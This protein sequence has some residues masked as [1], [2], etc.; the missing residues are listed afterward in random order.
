[1]LYLVRKT[2]N[3]VHHKFKKTH[4]R[5][6]IQ[7]AECLTG[8]GPA[9]AHLCH[10]AIPQELQRSEGRRPNHAPLDRTGC[11]LSLKHSFSRDILPLPGEHP[12]GPPKHLQG[13]FL[14]LGLKT[15]L[16]VFSLHIVYRIKQRNTSPNF[17]LSHFPLPSFF[18][19]PFA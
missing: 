15:C 8:H 12:E 17:S 1:M 6:V 9:E 10:P 5:C 7:V 3:N 2:V 4:C 19:I 18:I 16:S 11:L 14:V 13:D